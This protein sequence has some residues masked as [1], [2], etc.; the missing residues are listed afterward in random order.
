LKIYNFIYR[1]PNLVWHFEGTDG[2]P[3]I[4]R[5]PYTNIVDS[6]GGGAY[7]YKVLLTEG[8]GTV[9]GANFMTG[10]NMIFDVDGRRIGFAE[11]D[12]KYESVVRPMLPPMFAFPTMAPTVVGAPTVP[13][14]SGGSCIGLP[15]GMCSA[16]CDKETGSYEMKGMQ[17]YKD[18]CRHECTLSCDGYKYVF[19]S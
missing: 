17:D 18:G 13:D 10:Y 11:S 16:E 12:C 14:A 3:V 6:D 15:L 19:E 1:I 2:R 9:L 4:I 5:M 7:T 8:S